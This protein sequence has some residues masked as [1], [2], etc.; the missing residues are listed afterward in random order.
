VC[1]CIKVSVYRWGLGL[2]LGVCVYRRE[3]V[4]DMVGVGGFGYRVYK[5]R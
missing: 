1:G 4:R 5:Q 3:R 2:G